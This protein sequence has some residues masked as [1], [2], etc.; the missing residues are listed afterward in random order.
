MEQAVLNKTNMSREED[1][2]L[3]EK[4]G[5]IADLFTLL[6]QIDQRLKKGEQNQNDR[7]N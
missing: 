5:K 3:D 2:L 4:N 7:Y 6:I 1:C